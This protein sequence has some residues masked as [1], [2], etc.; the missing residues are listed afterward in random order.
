MSFL[1]NWFCN[2]F[3]INNSKKDNTMYCSELCGHILQDLG[4]LSKEIQ[5]NTLSPDSFEF[6]CNGKL[7]NKPLYIMK[8]N[9]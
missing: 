8:D 2:K 1:K 4:I 6:L 5:I 3:G 7:Y 9:V